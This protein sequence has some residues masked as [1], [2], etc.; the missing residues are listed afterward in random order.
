M[1]HV[2]GN[3]RDIDDFRTGKVGMNNK[4]SNPI[5]DCIDFS[6]LPFSEF[7]SAHLFCYASFL[8]MCTCITFKI[9]TLL[10]N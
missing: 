6:H 5:T 4:Y 2:L 8:E 7:V 1:A 10:P 3:V 9:P